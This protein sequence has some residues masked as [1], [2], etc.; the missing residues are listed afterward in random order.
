MKTHEKKT[1]GLHRGNPACRKGRGNIELD[2]F[3]K[4]IKFNILGR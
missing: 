1:K 3:R 4:K 2:S